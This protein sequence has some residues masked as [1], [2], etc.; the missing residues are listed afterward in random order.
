VTGWL[1]VFPIVL[2]AAAALASF[3]FV[4]LSTLRITNDGVEIRNYPQT[5]KTIPLA[6]VD[7]FVPAERVGLFSGLRPATAVLLL[8]DGTRVP[9]RSLGEPESGY[10]VDALNRR[11]ATLRTEGERAT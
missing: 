3:V 7:R 9:V 11:L 6:V 8:T 1:V 10:G 4:R 2:I 5:P